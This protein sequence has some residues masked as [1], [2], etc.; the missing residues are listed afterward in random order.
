MTPKEYL[1]ELY[2]A[3]KQAEELELHSIATERYKEYNAVKE[4]FKI[5]LNYE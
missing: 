5:V 2:K 4:A 1:N 3:Y